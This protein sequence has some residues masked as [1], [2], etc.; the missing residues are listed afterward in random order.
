MTVS[1][2]LVL[3]NRRIL[4]AF[5]AATRLGWCH[6]DPVLYDS[7]LGTSKADKHQL[8]LLPAQCQ[9]FLRPSL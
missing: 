4:L 7:A 2:A 5:P 1:Q 3:L 6:L 9:G 8:S